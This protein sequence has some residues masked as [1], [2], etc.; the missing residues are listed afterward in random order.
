MLAL[1]VLL[2]PKAGIA[3]EWQVSAVFLSGNASSCS[4]SDSTKMFM[5]EEGAMLHLMNS[6]KRFKLLTIP[7]NPDG[8]ASGDYEFGMM[9]KQMARVKASAGNGPRP[10]EYVLLQNVCAY[11]LE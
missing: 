8:S 11:R 1:I 7:L 5:V 2:S 4:T 9:R 3:A 10:V 6:S